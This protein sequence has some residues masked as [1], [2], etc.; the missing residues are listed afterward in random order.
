MC[1][2]S[3]PKKTVNK[4]QEKNPIDLGHITKGIPGWL[5][6]IV[7]SSYDVKKM[8]QNPKKYKW[9]V[10]PIAF[11]PEDIFVHPSNS[12]LFFNEQ[13]CKKTNSAYRFRH[14]DLNIRYKRMSDENLKEY[15]RKLSQLYSEKSGVQRLVLIMF[16]NKVVT[17]R[18]NGIEPKKEV[19][20]GAIKPKSAREEEQFHF[21]DEVS[22]VFKP[23]YTTRY[24][25]E[26][27]PVNVTING[28][29]S[30]V[31]SKSPNF[32]IGAT[33]DFL[34]TGWHQFVDN[35]YDR[36]MYYSWKHNQTTEMY[37]DTYKLARNLT[38]LK[39]FYPNPGYDDETNEILITCAMYMEKNVPCM[40]LVFFGPPRCGKSTMLRVFADIFNEQI[41]SGSTQT[42]RGL[43]GSFKEEGNIGALMSSRYCCL[44][45]EFFRTELGNDKSK[46]LDAQHIDY[47]MSRTIELLEHSEKTSSSGNFN[48]R[49]YLDKS[50][51][52]VN[53]IRDLKAFNKSFQ[54]DPASFARFSFMTM[55]DTE[56][57]RIKSS[58][59]PLNKCL[60]D[61][62]KEIKAVG[63][64]YASLAKLYR[65]WRKC[66]AFVDVPDTV[67][68]DARKRLD[69]A[70][71]E[72]DSREKLMALIK[73]R[74]ML[75]YT[76]S[77]QDPF[78]IL[79]SITPTQQDVNEAVR[80]CNRLSEGFKN[81][82][83]LP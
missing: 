64:D 2:I 46:T 32:K 74:T 24:R 38:S 15:S 5:F 21:F 80:F 4:K 63:F 11:I 68:N 55:R 53:N 48:R 13:G 83:G 34:A 9:R 25:E 62:R 69:F 60:N 44:C 56:I 29:N 31:L 23:Y 19:I 57:E 67:F 66:L 45:D 16:P 35:S 27:Y 49:M 54:N 28:I 51:I 10:Y 39:P 43:V 59:F 22:S 12:F 20:L 70:H 50:F 26:L 79:K 3:M 58:Y 81:I 14:E 76:I 77:N 61:F 8:A 30:T 18:V 78:P 36:P 42:V 6:S 17:G 75:N 52:S 72:Y 1:V 41:Q 7:N 73:A 71:S 37:F 47:I 82:V 40:N 33:Y 65:L